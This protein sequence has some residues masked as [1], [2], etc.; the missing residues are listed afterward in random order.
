M[1]AKPPTLNPSGVAF[2][3]APG[4]TLGFDRPRDGTL[5]LFPAKSSGFRLRSTWAISKATPLGFKTGAA[6]KGKRERPNSSPTTEV[7]GYFI[8]V[9]SRPL[10]V[11][12]PMFRLMVPCQESDDWCLAGR[13]DTCNMTNNEIEYIYNNIIVINNLVCNIDCVTIVCNDRRSGDFVR[14]PQ[15]VDSL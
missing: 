9:F 14:S 1:N 7:M 10:T 15:A 6:S 13:G 12:A 4:E 2:E 8:E 5:S 11:A 3:L